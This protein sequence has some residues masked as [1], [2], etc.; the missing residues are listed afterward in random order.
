[1][2][3]TDNNIVRPA[4]NV[5][6]PPDIAKLSFILVMDQSGSMTEYI[7]PDNGDF[8]MRA[9]VVKAAAKTWIDALPI[10]YLFL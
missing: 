6:C 3:I 9:T 7:D 10:G 8:R 1:M 5:D 2:Q 4:L